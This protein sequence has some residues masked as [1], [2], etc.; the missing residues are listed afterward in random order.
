MAEYR[1]SEAYAGALP[2]W[3]VNATSLPTRISKYHRFATEVS[4]KLLRTWRYFDLSHTSIH[5]QEYLG[6][7]GLAHGIALALPET[8]PDR[9]PTMTRLFDLLCVIDGELSAYV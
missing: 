5:G 3:G 8:S 7:A 1:Y 4:Q 2:D 9:I 6:R